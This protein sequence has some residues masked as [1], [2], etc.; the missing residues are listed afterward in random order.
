[1]PQVCKHQRKEDV[2]V[3]ILDIMS[4]IASIFAGIVGG[5]VGIATLVEKCKPYIKRRKERTE[6]DPS[7]SL[8]A[9][10]G[11]KDGCISNR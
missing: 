9:P 11:S 7:A 6:K 10:D 3:G 4:R 2:V 1:M 5:L 8:P